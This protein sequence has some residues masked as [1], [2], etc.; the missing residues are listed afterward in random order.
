MKNE[1][2]NNSKYIINNYSMLTAENSSKN[3]KFIRKNNNTIASHQNQKYSNT[4][5]FENP[6][7]DFTKTITSKKSQKGI[8]LTDLTI[9][10]FRDTGLETKTTLETTNVNFKTHNQLIKKRNKT[11]RDFNKNTLP[12]ISSGSKIP[13]HYNFGCCDTKLKPEYLTQLY[14][15]Q[16][17]YDKDIKNDENKN[18]KKEKKS[19]R[20]DRIEFLR[21]TN[22]IKRIK[23][24][25][26]IKKQAMEEY[27]ENIKM[28]KRGI[29]F[30]ISNLKT[31]RDHL[32][33]NFLTKYI[34]NLRKL[35]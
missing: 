28:Q 34:D 26:D 23:Y 2:S 35:E 7:R 27:K 4:A 5:L 19:L 3:S 20:E 25:M 6:R 15:E 10:K 13:H 8:Y 17:I 1:T 12:N 14:N 22:E 29:D 32:E 30:T 11:Q 33:N 31:Y 21:K 16:F 9:S 24:E 18:K